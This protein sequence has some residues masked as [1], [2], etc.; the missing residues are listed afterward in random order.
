MEVRIDGK[1]I[2]SKFDNIL[3]EIVWYKQTKLPN[4]GKSPVS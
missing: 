1:I 2:K 4:F 3:E